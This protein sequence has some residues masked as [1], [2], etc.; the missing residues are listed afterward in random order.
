MNPE[1]RACSRRSGP[2]CRYLTSALN[3]W[4]TNKACIKYNGTSI[5]GWVNCPYY[6]PEDKPSP[7]WESF[8]LAC[9]LLFYVTLTAILTWSLI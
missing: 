7:W 6:R 8:F 1:E 5:P 3:Y 4:C 2:D 9:L